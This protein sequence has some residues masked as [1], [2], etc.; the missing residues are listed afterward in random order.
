MNW[1]L[2]EIKYCYILYIEGIAWNIAVCLQPTHIQYWQVKFNP[3]RISIMYSTIWIKYIFLNKPQMN[4]CIAFLQEFHARVVGRILRWKDV[5]TVLVFL[6]ILEQTFHCYTAV[7][8]F[9]LWCTCTHSL[10][11]GEVFPPRDDSH[12]HFCHHPR[13]LLPINFRKCG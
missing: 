6:H 9:E 10:L 12:L 1:S 2:G 3:L 13:Y 5:E 8:N 7:K 11:T 4:I